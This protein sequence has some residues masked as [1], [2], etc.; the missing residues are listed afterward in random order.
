VPHGLGGAL[1]HCWPTVVVVVEGA[2]RAAAHDAPD[3]VRVVSAP[4]SGDDT[5]VEVGREAAVDGRTVVVT[6]DRE[7][8]E[9]VSAV[10]AMTAGPRWLTS[11]LDGR[12]VDDT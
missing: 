3:E 8:R 5:I 12:P 1:D 11:L 9:R 2:A 6:A 4:A 7:L 10:G